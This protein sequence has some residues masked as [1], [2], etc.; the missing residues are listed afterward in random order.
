MC[1]NA[2]KDSHLFCSVPEHSYK[3][4]ATEF[5]HLKTPFTEVIHTLLSEKGSGMH[6][7]IFNVLKLDSEAREDLR[8]LFCYP[9]KLFQAK[10]N[11][12][13]GVK[14]K[15]VAVKTSISPKCTILESVVQ[16]RDTKIAC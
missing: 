8:D 10:K 3:L 14:T 13:V 6:R 2:F 15:S 4:S 12:R 16:K 7:N 9:K 5:V 1:K 11:S